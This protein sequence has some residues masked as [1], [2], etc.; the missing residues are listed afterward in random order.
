MYGRPYD[1]RSITQSNLLTVIIATVSL[2]IPIVA[3][4]RNG[5]ILCVKMQRRHREETPLFWQTLRSFLSESAAHVATAGAMPVV[6][7]Q[8]RAVSA[9]ADDGGQPVTVAC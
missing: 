5:E 1:T 8:G 2:G 3:H 6:T 9:A 7:V 4:P